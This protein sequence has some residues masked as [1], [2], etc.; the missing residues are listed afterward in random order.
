[1]QLL[2]KAKANQKKMINHT[3]NIFFSPGLSGGTGSHDPTSPGS[4]KEDGNGEDGNGDDA[5]SDESAENDA[6]TE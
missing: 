6:S 2:F 4:N 1:L 5:K 3:S